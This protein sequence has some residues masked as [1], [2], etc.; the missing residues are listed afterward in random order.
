MAQIKKKRDKAKELRWRKILAA[1]QESGLS[2]NEFC[3]RERFNPNNFSWW[4]RE[5]ARRDQ[6]H[7][8]KTIK[9]KNAV[10]VF[11]PVAQFQQPKPETTA[12]GKP[13]AVAEFDI[14]AGTVKVFAGIDRASLREIVAALREVVS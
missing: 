4:K 1:Q 13:A 5:I 7:R 8:S 6:E 11:V 2:Q 9:D 12:V 3:R 10:P 14:A